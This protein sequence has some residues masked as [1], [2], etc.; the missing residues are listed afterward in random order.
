MNELWAFLFAALVSMYGSLMLGPV[1]L[2]VIKSSIV[3]G[4]RSGNLVALGGSLFP[5]I[6][7]SGIAM[8]AVGFIS[9]NEVVLEYLGYIV[10]PVMLILGFFY[11]NSKPDKNKSSIDKADDIDQKSGTNHFLKGFIL[12]ML[13]PQ[14]ITF[15][16]AMIL[17]AIHK[18]DFATYKFVS[19]KITFILG[20]GIGAFTLLYIYS[21]LAHRNKEKLKKITSYNFNKILG[22]IFF[23]LGGI[24]VFRVVYDFL[25]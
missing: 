21:Y 12:G 10:I 7:Y 9:E 6:I 5:E 17:I 15:W 3:T 18:I 4:R 25:K 23:I 1:N 22:I 13:N 11:Y 24:Q 19:P 20:T 2:V 14:L 16:T 8:F